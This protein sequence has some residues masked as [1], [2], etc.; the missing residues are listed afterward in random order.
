MQ[1]FEITL[2]NEKLK[3]YNRLSWIIIA[4]HVVIFLY[5]S[6][7]SKDRHI[8]SGYL[9]SLIILAAAFLLRYYLQRKKN[10]LQI[11]VEAFF[12][13]LMIA[14]ISNQQ[15]WLSLIPAMFYILSGLALRRLIVTFS[16]EKINYPS[17]PLK[18]INWKE[19]NNTMLKDGLLTIDFKNNK[20]IQQ[21]IDENKTSINEKEFNDFCTQQLKSAA[22]I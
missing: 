17:F 4:I 7:F 12:F 14:W 16:E 2:K 21:S 3:L 10:K 11:D 18:K 15:Y 19:L 9:A 13:L 22:V 20:L 8:A 6:L 1:Q 5:F